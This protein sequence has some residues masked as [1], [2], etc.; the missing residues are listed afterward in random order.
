MLSLMEQDIISIT[1]YDKR[2][3]LSWE[4]YVE[5][6]GDNVYRAV[7]NELFSDITIGTEFRTWINKE[8]QH[9]VLKILKASPYTTRQFM[10]SRDVSETQYRALG[11]E[12]RKHGGY[13]QTDMG[14]IASISLPAGCTM[15]LDELLRDLK[16][17]RKP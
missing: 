13:W 3:G 10:L 11:E 6:L 7:E 8:G 17:N 2:Q 5:P 9:Q 16:R 12:I 14:G 1:V 4:M 15:D